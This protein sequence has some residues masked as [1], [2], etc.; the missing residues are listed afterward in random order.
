MAVTTGKRAL[1]GIRPLGAAH[2]KKCPALDLIGGRRYQRRAESGYQR[3][4]LSRPPQDS[5][6]ALE[7]IFTFTCTVNKGCFMALGSFAPFSYIF[8]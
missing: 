2:A 3:R 8:P 5:T 6:G 1:A 4:K 7:A